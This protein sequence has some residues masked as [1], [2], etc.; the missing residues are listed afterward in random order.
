MK[1]RWLLVGTKPSLSDE[2][3]TVWPSIFGRK[4]QSSSR[5]SLV[6]WC[7]RCIGDR[8]ALR[9][10][11]MNSCPEVFRQDATW[12]TPV[13]PLKSC[14]SVLDVI[15]VCVIVYTLFQLKCDVLYTQI[16]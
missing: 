7:L 13:D 15:F 9:L 3:L 2:E 1:S 14:V 10:A 4:R 5:L 8:R 16:M 12:S 6:A 11:I